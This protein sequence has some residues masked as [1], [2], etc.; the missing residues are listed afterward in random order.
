[1]VSINQI[2]NSSV[3]RNLPQAD[4]ELI[5]TNGQPKTYAKESSVFNIGDAADELY[6][7]L[8]GRVCFEL[9]SKDGKLITLAIAE[10][11]M[12]I[13]DM[14]LFDPTARRSRARVL[15][16]SQVLVIP[17]QLILDISRRTP[18]VLEQFL[19]IYSRRL[20]AVS[21]DLRKRED[22]KLLCR[23]LL[24]NAKGPEAITQGQS[25][26][27]YAVVD[28]S[29]ETLSSMVGI[30]RQRINRILNGWKKQRWITVEYG[31]IIL[32]DP[33][34]LQQFCFD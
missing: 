1:M 10:P 22:D 19:K 11:P 30:P 25:E 9:Y 32:L 13:G 5:A 23:I 28:L 14:E 8:T 17:R 16:T 3:F 34:A 18:S 20:Q 7:L 15:E 29:Q 31:K 21:V 26:E 33:T 6:L 24:D 2:Q 4:L 27:D 12:V